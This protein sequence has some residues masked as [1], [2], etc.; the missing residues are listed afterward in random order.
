MVK[1]YIRQALPILL[2][3]AL[4]WYV[5]KDVS[6]T[7]II[8]QFDRANYG[9]LVL[10]GVLICLYYVIRAARW[11]I[12]L[13]AIGY[14]PSLFRT[15]IAIMAGTLTSM[16]I[17]GAGELT[18]CGTLQRTDDVPISQGVGTIVAERVVDL[19]MLGVVL[20]LTALLEFNR[21]Q[22]YLS[23]LPF[24]FPSLYV[25]AGMALLGIV[26][27]FVS[28]R[29]L[30]RRTFNENSFVAKITN[31][32]AG[33]KTG[34][35]AIRQLERPVIFIGLTLLSQL[36]SWVYTYVLLLASRDTEHLPPTAALMILAVGSLGGLAVPTQGGIGTYHF[37]VSRALLLYGFTA[38]QGALVATFLHTV[39]FAINLL[40]SSTS[41]LIL[42]TLINAKPSKSVEKAIK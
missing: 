1:G 26:A 39:G 3:I 7:E 31:V 37:L 14:S 9:W 33:F 11:Q 20:V 30:A 35:L 12:T 21:M 22:V 38:T 25:L 17:P 41:F 10:V 6:A 28:W 8:S 24:S 15:T 32:M 16:I 13:Q 29:L 34:F 2:A 23:T 5:L 42:P 4:L 18:R 27:I 36:L 19:L 40:L